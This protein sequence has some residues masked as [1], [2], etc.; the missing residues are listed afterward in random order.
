MKLPAQQGNVNTQFMAEEPR[1]GEGG[2]DGE[3]A[4]PFLGLKLGCG[5][6]G[7]CTRRT[8][9]NYPSVFTCIHF[10]IYLYRLLYL[11]DIN[12]GSTLWVD[13]EPNGCVFTAAPP[14]SDYCSGSLSWQTR[15]CCMQ[16]RLLPTVFGVPWTA[17]VVPRT[18]QGGRQQV[19]SPGG[20]PAL[21]MVTSEAGRGLCP[22][23]ARLD[24]LV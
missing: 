14:T 4:S 24:C 16:S 22:S 13:K 6:V 5:Y 17:G 10:Y 2:Q 8:G 11:L 9:Y 7:V 15:V 18:T 20:P 1:C 12:N 23:R 21:L 19:G 3:G